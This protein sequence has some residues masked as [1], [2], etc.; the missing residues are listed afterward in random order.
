MYLLNRCEASRFAAC[1]Y[2]IISAKADIIQEIKD[3]EYV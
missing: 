2:D 3:D 1:T